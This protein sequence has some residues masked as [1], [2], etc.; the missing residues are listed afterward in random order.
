M[1]KIKKTLNMK[2]KDSLSP[3][4]MPKIQEKMKTIVIKEIRKMMILESIWTNIWYELSTE[5]NTRER[6]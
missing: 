4:E 2:I 1:T 6:R 3:K 5:T